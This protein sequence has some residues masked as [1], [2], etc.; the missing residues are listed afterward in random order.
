MSARRRLILLPAL[1]ESGT[2]VLEG[3]LTL[4]PAITESGTWVLEGGGLILLPAITEKST[5]A[6]QVDKNNVLEA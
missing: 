5:F 4:L 6:G 2:W 3:G 1:T